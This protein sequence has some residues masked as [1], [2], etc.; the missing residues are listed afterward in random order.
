MYE[1]YLQKV[2]TSRYHR[3]RYLLIASWCGQ[4][5]E[6]QAQ[7]MVLG[8][9]HSRRVVPEDIYQDAVREAMKR[10]SVVQ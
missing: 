6:A 5:A 1:P 3:T 4:W 9:N 10:A 7:F 2:P 8:A